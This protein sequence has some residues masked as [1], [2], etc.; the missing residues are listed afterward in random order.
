MA[1]IRYETENGQIKEKTFASE[2][3]MVKWCDKQEQ[4][5]KT[6]KVLA[7]SE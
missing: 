3:A 5:G 4:A 2:E 1:T 6:V 7:Y